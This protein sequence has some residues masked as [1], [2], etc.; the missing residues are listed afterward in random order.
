VTSETA[1]TPH[2]G[3]GIAMSYA[4][5]ASDLRATAAHV[6][7]LG[8][9]SVWLSDSNLGHPGSLEPLTML[10]YLAATTER[11][12][13][14][15]S[16]LVIPS[17]VPVQLAQM[18]ATIDQLSGGR[19][20]A[21]V[22]LG[23]PD[24]LAAYGVTRAGRARRFDEAVELMRAVWQPGPTTFDGPTWRLDG[25]EVN[26]RPVQQPG[27]PLWFGGGSDGA[28]DRAA[29]YGDGWT[30]AG[31]SK[32]ADAG[33][34]AD[35]VRAALERHERDPSA[36]TIGKRVYVVVDDDEQRALGRIERE[37]HT[38]YGRP[39]LGEGIA[40]HGSSDQVTEQVLGLAAHGYSFVMLH[41]I[42]DQHEQL[43][44]LADS[45]VPALRAAWG[46]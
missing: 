12:R 33:A 34:L 20:I 29:R 11:L 43:A 46:S 22:G 10:G 44:L 4:D 38:I 36:F 28:I 16:V 32:F 6:E 8:F 19:L 24:H 31:M 15:V 1:R 39:G 45:V 2:V 23:H 26:P 5:P 40:V 7:A 14:G 18:L 41:P 21:G 13:L 30:N 42:D 25:V 37:F 3:A 27:V 17:K 9:D 35:R